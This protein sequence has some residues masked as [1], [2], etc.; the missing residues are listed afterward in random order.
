MFFKLAWATGGFFLMYNQKM[1]KEESFKL[2]R[3]KKIA[4]ETQKKVMN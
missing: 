2:V 1:R 3:S 4:F